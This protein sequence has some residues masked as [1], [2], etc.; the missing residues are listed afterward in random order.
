M[1]DGETKYVFEAM[2]LKRRILILCALFLIAG[3]LWDYTWTPDACGQKNVLRDGVVT[4]QQQIDG[5]RLPGDVLHKTGTS[6][7]SYR[8]YNQT[9]FLDCKGET[10]L[11]LVRRYLYIEYRDPRLSNDLANASRH[12]S[13]DARAYKTAGFRFDTIISGFQCGQVQDARCSGWYFFYG[14]NPDEVLINA[15]AW[16]PRPA[17]N[18]ASFVGFYGEGTL[19]RGSE[20]DQFYWVSF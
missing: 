2:S 19:F 9:Q 12:D 6:R 14:W 15:P 17:L 10:D 8:A 20:P 18:V 1:V 7:A 13:A 4:G 3:F 11:S 5:S 16:L